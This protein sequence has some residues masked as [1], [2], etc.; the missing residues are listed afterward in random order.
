MMAFASLVAGTFVSED[1][2]CVTAGLLIQRG[3]I[4]AGAGVLACTIGIFA[5]DLGLWAAGRLFG[6]TVFKWRRLQDS[7]IEHLRGSLARN[8][9][10]A[11]LA[12]R[13]V[14]GTRLPLYLLAG[15][16]RLSPAVFAGWTLVGAALWTPL[17][18]MFS[19]QL[20]GSRT[21]ALTIP[22]ILLLGYLTRTFGRHVSRGER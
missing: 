6:R 11:I 17:L 13:F 14:P 7:R 15:V 21:S 3:T 12:S 16:L 1:L 18:V 22:S 5:G 9:A 4:S 19:A 8:A 10:L 20:S 2:A